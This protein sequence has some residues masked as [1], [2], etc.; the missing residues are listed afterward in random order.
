MRAG[1]LRHYVDFQQV[2]QTRGDYGDLQDSWTS[3]PGLS[4]VPASFKS[5]RGQELFQAQSVN[6][7][8]QVEFRVRY[9]QG[10]TSIIDAE[11]RIVY[12]GQYYNILDVLPD[13]TRRRELVITAERGREFVT[14][15]SQ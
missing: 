3:A 2:T 11:M 6:N 8:A 1:A 5:L 9:Q 12:D 13:M 14:E 10:V 7:S 15:A 4:R